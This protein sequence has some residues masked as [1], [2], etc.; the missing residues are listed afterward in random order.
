MASRHC[1]FTLKITFANM[2]IVFRQSAKT[3]IVVIFGAVMGAV[4]IWLSTKYLPDKHQFGFVQTLTTYAVTLSQILLLG[5][6]YTLAVYIHRYANNEQ[7]RKLLLTL[8]FIVPGILTVV[9]SFFLF[10]FP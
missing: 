10:C 5:V 8:C 7:K 4:I 9:T 3:S 6:N 1:D 2:G